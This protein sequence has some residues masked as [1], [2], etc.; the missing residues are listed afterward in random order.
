[1]ERIEKLEAEFHKLRAK[2]SVYHHLAFAK[3]GIALGA[4]CVIAPLCNSEDG[5]RNA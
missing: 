3:A 4:G 2:G 5:Q 1:M